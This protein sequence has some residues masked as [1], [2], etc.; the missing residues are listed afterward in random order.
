M[1]DYTL[2]GILMQD[3]AEKPIEWIGDSR[4]KLRGFPTE[5]RQTMGFALQQ[6]QNGEK[7]LDAKPLKGFNGASVIAV[8]ADYDTD[9]FRVV[10]TVRFAGVVYVLHA[11]QKK[12]KKGRKTPQ[13]DID[14]I[15]QRLRT[16]R[17]HWQQH[18]K[19]ERKK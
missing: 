9:T 18:H 6:A 1:T 14:L 10:Y 7:H 19:V 3:R 13:H 15:R 4:R 16:A 11:F 8:V 12:S 5:V 2:W 17:D